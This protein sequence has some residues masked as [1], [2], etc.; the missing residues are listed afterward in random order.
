MIALYILLGIII[1]ITLILITS[2]GVDLRYCDDIFSLRIIAGPLKIKVIPAKEKKK[3]C[4]KLARRLKDKKI[5]EITFEK[6]KKVKKEKKK[7][8]KKLKFGRTGDT[9]ND[10]ISS[11]S[12]LSDDPE[13]LR[14]LLVSLKKLSEAFKKALKIRLF[15]LKASVDAGDAAKSCII[16]GG[17]NGAASLLLEFA[18]NNSKLYPVKDDTVKITPAFDNSGY[19]FD[20]GLSVKVRIIWIIKSLVASMIENSNIKKQYIYTKEGQKNE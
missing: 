8:K 14:F 1:L 12:E 3:S 11:V 7:E 10:F 2:V 20:I 13:S 19:I 6:K 5:S 18:D 9:V 15:S 17:L 4:K 16:C